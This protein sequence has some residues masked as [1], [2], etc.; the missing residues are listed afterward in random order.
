MN[1]RHGRFGLVL[2]T[3]K[4]VPKR[5]DPRETSPR[6]FG[7]ITIFE[8]IQ[9]F[10]RVRLSSEI[11][12]IDWPCILPDRV[13]KKNWTALNNHRDKVSLCYLLIIEVVNELFI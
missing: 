8:T 9:H 6:R 3:T 11:K 2:S 1:V 5:R 7:L 13:K 12:A 4:P 10:N